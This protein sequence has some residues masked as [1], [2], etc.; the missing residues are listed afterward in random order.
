[1]DRVVFELETGRRETGFTWWHGNWEAVQGKI[2]ES[3][4]LIPIPNSM[5]G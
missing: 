3:Y 1:M 5:I 4:V 2:L